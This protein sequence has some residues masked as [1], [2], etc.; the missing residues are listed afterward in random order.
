M[1]STTQLGV[2]PYFSLQVCGC[3]VVAHVDLMAG[4]EEMYVVKV[5][6]MTVHMFLTSGGT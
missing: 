6:R 4:L 1:N 3:F 2:S 5:R